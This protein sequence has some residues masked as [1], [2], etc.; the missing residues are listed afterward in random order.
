MAALSRE[1]TIKIKITQ[2][3]E[4]YFGKEIDIGLKLDN[5]KKGDNQDW[6]PDYWWMVPFTDKKDFQEAKLL[7]C[8]SVVHSIKTITSKE[9]IFF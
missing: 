9:Y 4:I 6:L 1:V 3:N 7:S 2:K 8:F 5:R